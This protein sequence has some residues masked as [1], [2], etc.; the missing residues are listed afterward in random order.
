MFIV[1]MVLLLILFFIWGNREW[2]S[3][4]IFREGKK[5]FVIK[6]ISF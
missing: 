3:L 5:V 4:R 2:D 6:D 1:T